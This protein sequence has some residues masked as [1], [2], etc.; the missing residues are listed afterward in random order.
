ML[1]MPHP[2]KHLATLHPRVP[3]P[4]NRH[5]VC[6]IVSKSISGNNL[7]FMS[8]RFR[9]TEDAAKCEGSIEDRKLAIRGPKPVPFS[10]FSQ[11]T[12]D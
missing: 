9:S 5:L 2:S 8:L 10:F 3:D 7:H 6:F 12:A 1:R 4:S 11:P